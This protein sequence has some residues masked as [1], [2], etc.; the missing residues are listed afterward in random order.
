MCQ[1]T[2]RKYGAFRFIVSHVGVLK[3]SYSVEQLIQNMLGLILFF[4][5]SEHLF[6][7]EIFF[8]LTHFGCAFFCFCINMY[9]V[10][11]KDDMPAA[12]YE[13][14]HQLKTMR[15]WYRMKDY[16]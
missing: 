15:E 13:N 11:P 5:E 12:K 9:T 8:H 4:R 2:T 3:S 16:Y 10:V 14:R 1:V 6:F 7:D